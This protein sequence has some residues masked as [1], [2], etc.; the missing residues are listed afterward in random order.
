MAREPKTCIFC[1]GNGLTDEHV[2]PDWLKQL[3]PKNERTGNLFILTDHGAGR[4]SRQVRQGSPITRQVHFVCGRCNT[5]WMSTLEDELKPT[6]ANLVLGKT[7]TLSEWQR[8]R[9]STWAVKTAMTS[10]YI[11]PPTVAIPFDMREH[12]RL[13]RQPHERFDVWIG[14]YNGKGRLLGSEHHS[15]E[16]SEPGTEP[17]GVPNTQ[18]TT[19]GLGQIFFQIAYCGVPQA[20]FHLKN[21][22]ISKMRRIW[23]PTE[24]EMMWPPFLVLDADDITII[25]R[26]IHEAFEDK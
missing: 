1:R 10:E 19:I 15:G 18:A 7:I 9:L 23:P 3:I 5:G 26:G 24:G 11:H 4:Q 2:V 13:H 6:L 17:T 21:E 8:R 25:L 14:F 16:F 20:R 22:K 12:L